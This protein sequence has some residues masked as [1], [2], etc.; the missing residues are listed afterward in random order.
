MID[1]A[2]KVCQENLKRDKDNKRKKIWGGLLTVLEREGFCY[3]DF[4]SSLERTLMYYKE[5]INEGPVIGE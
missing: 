2:I 3:E 1:A 4:S 5:R